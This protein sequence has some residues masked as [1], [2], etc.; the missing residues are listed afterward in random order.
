MINLFDK[1]TVDE[2]KQR[3]GRL[4]PESPREWGT[5]TP[6]QALA[7]CS[8]GIE[9]ALGDQKPPRLM[10]GRILGPVIKRMALGDDAPMRRNSPTVPG[11]VGKDDVD[12]QE[13]QMR[14]IASVNR[15]ANDGPERC[16]THPHAFFGVMTPQQWAILTYKHVDHHLRQFG[17]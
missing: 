9:I 8:L 2:V 11:M 12:F 4:T 1:P 13:E 17:V 5:M 6:A 3:I 7:H 10:V 14:L 15:F 16:T